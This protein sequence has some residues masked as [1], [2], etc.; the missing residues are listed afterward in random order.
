[1]E[2]YK[3]EKRYEEDDEIDLVELLKSIIREKKLVAVITILF[4]ILAGGFAFYKNSKPYNYGVE[5]S[6]SEY[7]KNKIEQYN[8]SYKNSS[9]IFNQTIQNTFNSLLDK[10]NPNV[11]T[12]DSEDEGE[13]KE[14]LKGEY[15]FVK[16]VDSKNKTY[17]LF[18]KTKNNNI[19][20]L[21][22]E[23][24]NLVIEDVKNLNFEFEKNLSENII[25][26]EKELSKL[27]EETNKLNKSAMKIIKEN[28]SDVSKE[29]MSSN[30]SIISPVLYVEYQEKINSLNDTYLKV[31]DLNKIKNEPKE[32]FE[33]SGQDNITVIKFNNTSETSGGLNS[34][35]II[36][37]GIIFGLFAGMFIAIIKEPL[38]NILKEIKTEK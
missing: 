17:K 29:N 20:T 10:T 27:T 19:E 36:A 37:I 5:I 8:T 15:H 23:I 2:R 11:I 1:M 14:V 26:A 13:I 3:L 4:T 16:I 9:I 7:T 34:K 25:S 38:K 21:S 35:L 12:L 32:L 30:F 33:L 6:L 31:I 28:F 18:T 24:N 22:K